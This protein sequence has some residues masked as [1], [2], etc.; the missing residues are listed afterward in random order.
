MLLLTVQWGNQNMLYTCA[1]LAI[2]VQCGTISECSH[3]FM[4]IMDSHCTNV[5]Q[6][7]V[8]A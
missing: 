3:C 1:L 4:H 8:R 2:I 6:R 7:L 5:V